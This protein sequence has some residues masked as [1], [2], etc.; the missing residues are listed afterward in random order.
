[1]KVL[2]IRFG[3]MGDLVHLSPSF[4]ALNNQH[5]GVT[6]DLLTSAI[7]QPIVNNFDALNQSLFWD[8]KDGLPALFQL[9]VQLAGERYD[10]VI[11]LHPSLKTGLFCL[12]LRASKTAV[13]RKERL[14]VTGSQQ[15]TMTRRHAVEDFYSVFQRA[16][17]R[18][19]VV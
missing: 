2:V 10:A 15:R 4:R 13:Y 1:M 8:K 11:N 19:S 17:D 5:P 3:A 16:L 14:R 18:K 6:I 9:A 7:Y 12:L